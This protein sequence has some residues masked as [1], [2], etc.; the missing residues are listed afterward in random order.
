MLQA[1]LRIQVNPKNVIQMEVTVKGTLKL[2]NLVPEGT[3]RK[4]ELKVRL[5]VLRQVV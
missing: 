5:W 2:G 1:R 4:V 3:E